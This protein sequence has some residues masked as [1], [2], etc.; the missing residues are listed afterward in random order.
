MAQEMGKKSRL[1][2]IEG[3]VEM[4]RTRFNGPRGDVD[5]PRGGKRCFE[6]ELLRGI[7]SNGSSLVEAPEP[8]AARDLSR[9]T[10]RP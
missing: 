9:D 8:L 4:L 2:S 7:T 6:F 1:D 5:G 10:H 3:R